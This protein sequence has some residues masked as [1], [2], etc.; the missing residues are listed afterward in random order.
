[1]KLAKTDRPEIELL[2]LSTRALNCLHAEGITKISQLMNID[3]IQLLKT[4]NLG[5]VTLKEIKDALK[6]F[7]TSDEVYCG[8]IIEMETGFVDGIYYSRAADMEFLCKMA[9]KF[10][11]RRPGMTHI[12]CLTVTACKPKITD[13]NSLARAP[14]WGEDNEGICGQD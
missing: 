1:M 13:E 4:P 10:S 3:E 14:V 5:R 9:K 8:F 7:L 2:N 11:K 6:D 12:P